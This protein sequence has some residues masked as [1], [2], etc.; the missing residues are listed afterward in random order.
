MQRFG[1][2]KAELQALWKSGSV[3]FVNRQVSLKDVTGLASTTTGISFSNC[4][5]KEWV[6]IGEHLATIP[7]LLTISAEGCDSGDGLC[8]GVR[9]STSIREVRFGKS[10]FTQRTAACLMPECAK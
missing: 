5:S 6:K 8:T 3:D 10:C 1:E 9:R 2:I 7:S 4:K